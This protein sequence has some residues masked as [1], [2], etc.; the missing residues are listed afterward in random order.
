[1]LKHR[2]RPTGKPVKT[3]TH[4][5][6]TLSDMQHTYDCGLLAKGQGCRVCASAH[7]LPPFLGFIVSSPS[8]IISIFV[9]ISFLKLIVIMIFLLTVLLCALHVRT[10]YFALPRGLPFLRLRTHCIPYAA[11]KYSRTKNTGSVFPPPVFLFTVLY[12]TLLL[13]SAAALDFSSKA[14]PLPYLPAL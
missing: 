6:R 5:T 13:L 1:M 4:A 9:P 12:V 11:H 2:L 14:P 7:F 10:A 8:D 3:G